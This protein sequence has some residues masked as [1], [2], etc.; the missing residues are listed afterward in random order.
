MSLRG[1]ILPN[2]PSWTS[3]AKWTWR[4]ESKFA[5]FHWQRLVCFS[6]CNTSLPWHQ[7]LSK[8][9]LFFSVSVS[10]YTSSLDTSVYACTKTTYFFSLPKRWRSSSG[11]RAWPHL[12]L[13]K[14][15]LYTLIFLLKKCY[16][17]F[18]PPPFVNTDKF[19]FVQ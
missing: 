12:V 15:N 1:N 17:V 16:I 10:Y 9:L 7:F 3:V 4:V 8:S 5:C 2:S 13:K 18:P 14:K 6:I 11:G 19:T